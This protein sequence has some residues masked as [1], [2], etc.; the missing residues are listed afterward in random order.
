M[1]SKK[2]MTIFPLIKGEEKL[3]TTKKDFISK[4]KVLTE[5]NYPLLR[6]TNVGYDENLKEYA[7]ELYDDS[8]TL[9]KI[10]DPGFQLSPFIFT[11]IQAR[12]IE[13]KGSLTLKYFIRFNIWTY[14][15]VACIVLCSLYLLYDSI[16]LSKHF[17]LK[18]SL[19][20]IIP[21]PI[22]LLVFIGCAKGDKEFIRKLST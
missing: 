22:S 14:I 20:I 3:K 21:Y 18:T 8:F 1:L 10:P 13:N 2:I 19:I 5:K 6:P 12:L 11:V 4:L 17:E 9:W 16:F 7:R 15:L